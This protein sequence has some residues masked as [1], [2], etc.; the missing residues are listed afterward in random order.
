ML[1]LYFA[2]FFKLLIYSFLFFLSNNAVLVFCVIGCSFAE[3]IF[4][5]KN[6][7]YTSQDSENT[8]IKNY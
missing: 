5:K 1:Q 4:N 7:K 2:Y 6:I 3:K 8:F